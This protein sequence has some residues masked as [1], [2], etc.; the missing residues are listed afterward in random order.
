MLTPM[1]LDQLMPE[2]E[3]LAPLSLAEGWDRV[4][5]QIGQT[6]QNI[7]RALLCIDLTPAVVAEAVAAKAKLIVAYHP[8][9]FEPIRTLAGE[10][11][12]TRAVRDSVR[13]G[14]A[15]YCPHTALDAAPGGMNDWLAEGLGAG[16]I[17][18]MVP[19]SAAVPRA[20]KLVVFVPEAEVT[21]VRQALAEAGAGGIGNYRECSFETPGTGGFKPMPGANPAI[22]RVGRRETVAE[23]RLEMLV[24]EAE[25]PQA[26][27]ALRQKHPYEEPAFDVIPLEPLADATTAGSG[28]QPGAG[29]LLELS[30]PTSAA[31]LARRLRARLKLRRVRLAKPVGLVQDAAAGPIRTVAVCVG[32]GGKLF[33][34]TQADAYVTGEMTH[35]QVLDLSQRGAAVILAGHTHTERPYLR[36]YR[37]RLSRVCGEVDWLVSRADRIPW[38]EAGS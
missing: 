14:I 7:K 25:L 3:S 19:S 4:G 18:P 1:K 37:K 21:S 9:I 31:T 34:Q 5:L 30:T 15:V 22:G 26:I 20:F 8:V 13:E 24:H 16:E 2:I 6:H 10:H 11:W 33:E 38:T 17:R 36:E 32:S 12:K 35:H 23:V 28:D 29:R 27:Q